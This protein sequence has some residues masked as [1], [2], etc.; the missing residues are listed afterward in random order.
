MTE[1]EKLIAEIEENKTKIVSDLEKLKQSDDDNSEFYAE[2]QQR[3]AEIVRDLEGLKT[4]E[5]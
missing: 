4:D 2:L 5:N 3:Q 1:R